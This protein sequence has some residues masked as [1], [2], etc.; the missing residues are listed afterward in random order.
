MNS[1]HSKTPAASDYEIGYGRSPAAT[2]F[3]PGQ[4][5][6]PRGRPKGARS[7]G[8]MLQQALNR[9][10]PVHENGRE[11]RIR[12]QDA[13]IH[14]LVNDAARRNHNALRL[15]FSLLDRYGQSGETAI[16]LGELTADDSAIIER[17][18]S[19][20]QQAPADAPAGQ[21]ESPQARGRQG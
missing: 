10:V 8:Q 15:L 3:Q 2:R 7:I 13:I 5:G 14:G 9:R 11:R 4:S 20:L 18:I 1:G 12:L 17:Y 21:K 6:N 16:N 19:T